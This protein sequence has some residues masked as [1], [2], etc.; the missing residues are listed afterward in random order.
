MYYLNSDGSPDTT[1]VDE[2][3]S[4]YCDSCKKK[5]KRKQYSWFSYTNILLFIIL[6]VGIVVMT[7]DSKQL[8]R[9]FDFSSYGKATTTTSTLSEPTTSSG[10][11]TSK[12]TEAGFKL[13][14]L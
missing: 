9:L 7:V 8:S 10:D 2:F 3:R 13:P 11:V 4:C 5:R 6:I 14:L 1:V 12:N